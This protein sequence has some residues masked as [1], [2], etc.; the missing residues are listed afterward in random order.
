M[1][2]E[3]A[4]QYMT[5][6]WKVTRKIATSFEYVLPPTT[7]LLRT[8]QKISNTL[9]TKVGEVTGRGMYPFFFYFTFYF[10][11]FITCLLFL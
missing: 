3:E 5:Q 7:P 10:L 9:N 4:E 8:L 2:P 6:M 1:F 11:L